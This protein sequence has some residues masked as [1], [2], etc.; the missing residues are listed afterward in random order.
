MRLTPLRIRSHAA[1]VAV[2][3]REVIE[4]PV[5]VG[6]K[7]PVVRADGILTGRDER[8]VRTIQLPGVD[9]KELVLALA[10]IEIA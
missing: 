10:G 4:G 7:M 9:P 3:G 6:R 2:A 5:V 1:E 8:P